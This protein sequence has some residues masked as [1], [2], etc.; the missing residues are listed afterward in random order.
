MGRLLWG[1]I[2]LLI[3]SVILVIA[4]YLVGRQRIARHRLPVWFTIPDFHLTN[5][6]AQ[7]VTRADLIGTVWVADIIFT[8]CA[9]PCPQMTQRM[10][11]LQASLPADRRVRL[12]T[13]TTD[14]AHDTPTVLKSYGDRF[15]AQPDRWWFLTGDPRAIADL[16]RDGFKF[17]A[18]EKKLEARTDPADL[19][20]HSTYFVVVDQQGRARAVFEYAQPEMNERLRRTVERLLREE[21]GQAITHRPTTP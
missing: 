20:V 1:G 5:Q 4:L 14:A 16:A 21:L 9:G 11:E 19:F 2:L 15:G 12:V 18:A 6:F 10:G 13:L 3:T 17:V 7:P 8:R